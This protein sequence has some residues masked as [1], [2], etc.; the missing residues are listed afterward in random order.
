M[1]CTSLLN[2]HIYQKRLVAGCLYKFLA[3]SQNCT[4]EISLLNNTK[5]VADVN[6]RIWLQINIYI[7]STHGPTVWLKIAVCSGVSVIPTTA[8]NLKAHI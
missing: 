5:G 8:I 7:L 1:N 3:V 6:C 4:S 2:N